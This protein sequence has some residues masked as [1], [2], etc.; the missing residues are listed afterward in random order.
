M[1]KNLLVFL[2]FLIF[3][4]SF[5]DLA[6]AQVTSSGVGIRTPIQG[7]NI[8]DASIICTGKEGL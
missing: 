3:F 2:I 4:L 5:T 1:H 7:E 8:P 6:V